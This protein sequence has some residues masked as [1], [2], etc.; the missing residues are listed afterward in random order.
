MNQTKVK[1]KTA[2]TVEFVFGA[3]F[4]FFGISTMSSMMA[5]WSLAWILLGAFLIV[6]ALEWR[7]L[8]R[9]YKTYSTLLAN[10]PTGSIAKISQATNT[11]EKTVRDNLK[12]MIK[13]GIAIDTVI[14]EQD[15]TVVTGDRRAYAP[16]PSTVVM[17]TAATPE[18]TAVSCS[19]CGAVNNIP[20]G[21]AAQCEHC[22]TPIS[23]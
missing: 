15:G 20:K 10:D 14:N 22:G 13:K 7:V 6:N 8:I 18:I 9:D 19:G 4:L 1:G 11:S 3:L 17:P 21:S 16:D 23:A 12:L 5:W 2:S